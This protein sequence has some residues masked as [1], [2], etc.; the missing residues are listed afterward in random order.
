MKLD[1]M[2]YPVLMRR[3]RQAHHSMAMLLALLVMSG[4]ICQSALAQ[5][6]LADLDIQSAVVAELAANEEV[7]A[8]FVDV[9]LKNGIVTLEGWV[10]NILARDK[11]VEVAESI[12]GVRSVIS[13]IVVKP[14]VRSDAEIRRDVES[15]L[16]ADPATDMY[17]LAVNVEEGTVF[18]TG[19]VDSYQEKRLC[20][21]VV[22][23]VIGVRGVENNIDFIFK[24][25]RPD[26]EIQAE[27]QRLLESDVRVDT[28]DIKVQVEDGKVTLTGTATSAMEKNR[29]GWRSWIAGVQS[30]DNRI[31]VQWWKD[32]PEQR[33]K[34][35]T[36]TDQEIEK[37]VMATLVNDPRVWSF[38]VEADSRHGTVTLRGTVDNLKAKK[39]AVADARHTVGVWSVIDE[40]KV[41][42]LPIVADDEIVRRVNSALERNPYLN[43][44]DVVVM[45]YNGKVF[46]S[47]AVGTR[48]ERR[49]AERVAWAVNG[50]AE[51]QND[52][53]VSR[54]WTY[55]SDWEINRDVESQ[56]FWSPFVDSDRIT[57]TV[58]DGVVMLQGTVEDWDEYWT[59]VENAYEGGARL[60][61]N[62]LRLRKM[63]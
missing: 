55:K 37:A 33:T 8:H 29:A 12:K 31:E 44:H 1:K 20:S 17:Q 51:V 54:Y 36:L 45:S 5:E 22:K 4:F 57:V 24:E 21:E 34:Y 43:R 63:K 59:A 60:V 13:M 11:A 52:I 18:L 32:E 61:E 40:I 10:S 19:T 42:P 47:G 16:F 3:F 23:G 15:A 58:N 26:N 50:V 35:V 48:F 7:D 53:T 2:K 27:I 28:P 25:E 9:S 6:K 41:R 56:L 62:H 46:L 30:V 39:A 49:E 38:Q 14:A